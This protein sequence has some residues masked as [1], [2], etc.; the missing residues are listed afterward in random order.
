MTGT[1]CTLL[2]PTQYKPHLI[3]S[4]TIKSVT[5][6]LLPLD[7]HS[8]VLG[9]ASCP[10]QCDISL[11]LL[12]LIS[13]TPDFDSGLSR[14][15][16]VQTLAI[17]SL[18]NLLGVDRKHDK[19]VFVLSQSLY[20]AL[21]RLQTAILP[22][23]INRNTNGARIL[24]VQTRSFQLLQS[25]SASHATLLVV[26]YGGTLYHGSKE[27]D[28]T[29]S[30]FRQLPGAEDFAPELLHGLVEPSLDS[31]LPFLV[32]MSIR[33]H[34]IVTDHAATLKDANTQRWWT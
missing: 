2:L 9:V 12:L 22:S 19:S 28:G 11:K 3:T 23:V 33:N 20:V 5:L 29:R 8:R 17:I 27:L 13:H 15:H 26:A 25:K 4:F 21:K 34:I 32:E 1:N 6:D 30:R 24:R 16:L 14:S 31:A 18:D 7:S 10:P